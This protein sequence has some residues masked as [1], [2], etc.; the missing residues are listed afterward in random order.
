MH[1][2]ISILF[3]TI[4]LLINSC[5]NSHSQTTKTNLSAT[6]FAGKIKELPSAII[7]DVRTP[8]EFTQG[9]IANAV[10]YDMS[11]REFDNQLSK[12][13]KSKPVLVYCLSGARSASAMQRMK[14]NGFTQVYNLYGGIIRW[15]SE[16]LPITTG[17]KPVAGITR[18]QFN[19]MIISDK[20][21]LVDFYAEWCAPCKRMEP[22][23]DEISRDMADKVKVIRINTDK[24]MA[25]SRELNVSAIPVLQLY[26]NNSLIWTNTGY[27]DKAG[28]VEKLR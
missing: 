19:E 13:D 14:S 22:Y 12:L 18:S 4:A 28:V 24:N 20:L 25:L 8:G 2:N 7:L 11:N 6:E 27:I 10:N 5:T 23:L 21:V 16:N 26:K 15:N 17:S 9:H 1:T 3:I